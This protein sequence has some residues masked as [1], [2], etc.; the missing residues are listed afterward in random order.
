[1]LVRT[2]LMNVEMHASVPRPLIKMI[3]L[4][5]R[6]ENMPPDMIDSRIIE[7]PQQK[8]RNTLVGTISPEEGVTIRRTK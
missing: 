5:R 1:M 6:N 3:F 2:H 8:K 4:S 7:G